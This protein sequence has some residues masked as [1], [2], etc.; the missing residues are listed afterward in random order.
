MFPNHQHSSTLNCSPWKRSAHAHRL[1]GLGAIS[2]ATLYQT[3]IPSYRVDNRLHSISD[4][5][6]MG[7]GWL[8]NAY[9]T[10]YIH[11]GGRGEQFQAHKAKG[12]FMGKEG[13]GTHDAR[14]RFY[15]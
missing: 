8:V 3:L 11:R 5:F 2:D 7:L 14:G 4:R 6:K 12:A 9:Y 13:V 1:S 10:Y 15:I